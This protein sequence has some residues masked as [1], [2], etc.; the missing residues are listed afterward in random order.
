MTRPLLASIICRIFDGRAQAGDIIVSL[1]FSEII[2]M[3]DPLSR[4]LSCQPI[5]IFGRQYHEF[6]FAT[7]SDV[8]RS[9]ERSLH[10]FT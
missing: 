4:M 10:H 1:I 5:I 7:A 2:D 9:T 6:P 3:D 8:D